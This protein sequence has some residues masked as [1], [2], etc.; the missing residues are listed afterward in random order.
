MRKPSKTGLA[1]IAAVAVPSL[2]ACGSDAPDPQDDVSITAPMGQ[3]WAWQSLS[4]TDPIEV[5]SPERYTLEFDADGRYGIR[6]DCNTGQGGYT[7]DG[8]GLVLNPG[9]MT[10]AACLPGSY[11]SQFAALLGEVTSAARS[12]DQLTLGLSDGSTMVF[13]PLPTSAALGGSETLGGTNWEVSAYNNGRGGVTT[14][15]AATRM[16]IAF[17]E[18]GTVSGSSGCNTFSGI[19]TAD[20][21]LIALGP[22]AS[23]Q[24][25]CA[26]DGVMEQEEQFLA[27]LAASSI[28]EIRGRRLQL[29]NADGALQ[30]DLSR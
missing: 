16:S 28:Y 14:L 20:D 29:R 23:T 30:V 19:Y 21:S 8:G 24:K 2:A 7:F 27:A 3:V 13:A 15:V 17:S 25:M 18:D 1:V 4:G 11:G 6:A 5:A 22:T 26:A 9:P 10:L 12:G